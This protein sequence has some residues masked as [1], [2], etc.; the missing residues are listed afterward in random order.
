MDDVCFAVATLA[1]C[2]AFSAGGPPITDSAFCLVGTLVK[3]LRV[4]AFGL[5][6]TVFDATVDPFPRIE[7]ASESGLVSPLVPIIQYTAN[8]V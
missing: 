2:M 1:A 4:T 7:L 3:L 5:M 8:P 6:L